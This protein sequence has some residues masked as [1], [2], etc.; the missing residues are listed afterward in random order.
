[1]ADPIADLLRKSPLTD[2]QRADAWDAFYQAKDQDDL[3]T[4]LQAMKLPD[5]VKAGLW[6][7]KA[8]PPA[9]TNSV[10]LTPGNVDL[11]KQ[12]KVKNPDGSTSTVDSLSV[13]IDGKEVL[14]PTVT[15]D[16]RHLRNADEAVAEYDKTGL[17]LG[18]F[19]DVASANA[20]AKQLHE[21][22]A[23]GKYEQ[24][25]EPTPQ[26]SGG[27]SLALVAAR[28]SPEAARAA[29]R[30]AGR[31]AANHPA[32]TQRLINAG[33]RLAASGVGGSVAGVPGA[34]A[35]LAVAGV[36]PK[37]ETIRTVG[38]RLAGE[39]KP[40]AEAAGKALG[41]QNYIKSTS[42]VKVKPTDIL[43]PRA[44]GLPAA[45]KYAES[46]GRELLK[47]YGPNGEVVAGPTA[48][49]VDA[50]KAPSAATKAAARTAERISKFL[51]LLS[52]LQGATAVTDFAQTVE[53][54]RGDI[55]VMGVGKAKPTPQFSEAEN[56]KVIEAMN[57]R[58][59]AQEAE[60]AEMLN[61][62]LKR[63]GLR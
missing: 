56:A 24:S 63:L 37:Q 44:H 23:A 21:D 14:L 33:V 32:A 9:A 62:L 30:S 41:I 2:A 20:Y 45:E 3:A 1:M 16:G 17:H 31:F 39:S 22:Y 50:P 8:S 53:P 59:A 34:I 7:Q 36:T 12:P 42:G 15:P 25:P 47:I 57:K 48:A 5:T 27:A 35:G 4:K 40:V 28:R 11:F 49:P 58:L 29:T 52:K 18:I 61:T 19:S 26:G 55:G 54:T 38:G 60:R 51:P 10:P 13:N 46:M 43:P 6:D